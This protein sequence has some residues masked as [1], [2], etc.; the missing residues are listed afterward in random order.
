M[1]S[2]LLAATGLALST[3]T[4]AQVVSWD[5]QKR[6]DI[7][8]LRRR[9]SATASTTIKNEVI[10]G[11]YF[12][13]VQIGTPGQTMTLQ[14]DTGSSDLWV[15]YTGAEVCQQVTQDNP[16]CTDGSFNPKKSSTFK[17]AIQNGFDAQYVDNSFAKGD[18]F[19]DTLQ[20]DGLEV[21]EMIMGLGID[22]NI[23][24]GL[25][26]IAYQLDES[27]TQ[28][29][30]QI[31]PNLPSTLQSQGFVNSVGYSLW[32]NDLKASTGVLL[33]GGVDTDKFS[34]DLISVPV[35]PNSKVDNYTAMLVPLTSV[36][37]SS[38][39]GTD[40][41]ASNGALPA[42]LDSGTTLTYLPQDLAELAWEE[43]GAVWTPEAGGACV[44]CSFSSSNGVFVYQFG[45]SGGPSINVSMSE[46]TMP[47]S[48]GPAPQF[49]SGPYQGQGACLFGIQNTTGEPF[50]LGDTF[51][52]SAY[53]VYDLVNNEIALAQTDFD[54]TSSNIV[55]F[56]SYGA[57]IPSATKASDQSVATPTPDINGGGSLSAK[58]GFQNGGSGSGS[59]SGSG[60]SDGG[61]G[62]DAGSSL[63]IMSV[64]GVVM[65][66]AS[67][68]F[69]LFQSLAL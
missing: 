59:S 23:A 60:G 52:R 7:P 12:A 51:L 1:K 58:S 41:L 66:G 18:Y 33:F 25:I 49:P 68:G 14:I 64:S 24:H 62:G 10:D 34:G 8:D 45:G 44:P 9:S 15:V 4:V 30:R 37:A 20:L 5:I 26:G 29:E 48:S 47:L 11:G 54:A 69:A 27:L 6:H 65:I 22:C 63:A 55:P 61:D 31:Y 36:S 32:L 13:E 53:V 40:V 46:L 39:S 56:A 21:K 2:T 50:L 19:Q 42:V 17:D 28:T 38:S 35:I 16:G 43:A 57:S 3:G 67:V